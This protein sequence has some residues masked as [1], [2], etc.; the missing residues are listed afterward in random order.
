[1]LK[2][3]TEKQ[4]S[5]KQKQSLVQSISEMNIIEN[6]H[7]KEGNSQLLKDLFKNDNATVGLKN[8]KI[9]YQQI[10]LYHLKSN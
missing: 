4:L 3:E 2:N 7:F 9:T 1:M 8:L 10:F 5:N 6:L